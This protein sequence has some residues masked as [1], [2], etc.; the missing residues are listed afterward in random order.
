[1]LRRNLY[2]IS[3][4]LL[5]WLVAVAQH[6][7]PLQ[8]KDSVEVSSGLPALRLQGLDRVYF[9]HL[10]D[11]G[12]RSVMPHSVS[13]LLPEVIQAANSGLKTTDK[14]EVDDK[15]DIQIRDLH[16][17]VRDSRLLLQRSSR[18]VFLRQ[19]V[20]EGETTR[21]TTLWWA[22]YDDDRRSDVWYF[23]VNPLESENKALSNYEIESATASGSDSLELRVRGMMFRPQG[24]F[25]ITGKA[26]SF[27]VRDDTLA[28][29]RVRNV[30]G[31]FQDYDNGETP[32]SM[33]VST[34]RETGGLFKTRTYNSVPDRV[35]RHCQFWN[36]FVDENW[37]FKWERMERNALC[38]TQETSAQT[39]YRSLGEPSFV[40]RGGKAND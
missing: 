19:I 20:V 2:G 1:M 33:N 35:L 5:C 11:P 9:Q 10:G 38:V 24:A 21:V 15:N 16:N 17:Q 22:L 13:A 7:K 28:L 6:E 4:M 25:W 36:P 29:S 23:S 39:S 27:S 32:P 37:E 3:M 30:F 12:D 31:F 40:E 18:K 8:R 34:E 14:Q 26:F